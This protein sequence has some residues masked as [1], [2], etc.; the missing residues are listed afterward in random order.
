MYA[1]SCKSVKRKGGVYL[2]AIDDIEGVAEPWQLTVQLQPVG[3]GTGAAALGACLRHEHGHGG[4]GH[5]QQHG[6]RQPAH[7]KAETTI[8]GS[9]IGFIQF[10]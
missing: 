2:L 5:Q 3:A 8:I 6:P 9:Y 7:R 10:L 4:H 1:H